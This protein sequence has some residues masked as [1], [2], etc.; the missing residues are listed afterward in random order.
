[1]SNIPRGVR[2]IPLAPCCKGRIRVTIITIQGVILAPTT[3]LPR[4]LSCTLTELCLCATTKIPRLQRLT[5]HEGSCLPL[6]Y[7]PHVVGEFDEY[8]KVALSG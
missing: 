4:L 7:R 6:K 2:T 3:R 5:Q 8:G 1:M